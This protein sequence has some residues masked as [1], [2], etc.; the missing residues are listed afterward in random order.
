MIS[1]AAKLPVR[2]GWNATTRHIIHADDDIHNHGLIPRTASEKRRLEMWGKARCALIVFAVFFVMVSR[3][4]HSEGAVK[5]DQ[6]NPR[7][8]KKDGSE[9]VTVT[10]EHGVLKIHGG[11]FG[12]DT[13]EMAFENSGLFLPYQA[14]PVGSWPEA[15]AIGDV[16]N[17]GRNDVV[18]TTSRYFDPDN[19]YHIFVFLQNQ[20]GELE[21][22]V[23]YPAGNGESID[24]GDVNNDGKADVLVTAQD[25]IGVFLQND[26]GGLDPMVTYPSNHSSHSNTYKVGIGD[27]NDD[28][29]LDVVSID[30]GTQSHDV[31]VFLQNT[32]GTLNPPV[33]YVVEHG[34]W[35]DLEVGDVNTDGLQDIIVMSGQGAY[36]DI[37]I[38]LQREDGIFEQPVYY[39]LGSG[40]L[41]RGVGVGDI[42]GDTLE[43]IVVSYG[44][45]RPNSFIATFLQNSTGALDP[46]ISYSSYDIPEPVEVADVDLD[47]RNDV[48]VAH[49]GWNAMGVYLQGANGTL[50][51]Y[52]LYSLPY[53]SHYN[54]HGLVV[55]D[56]SGDGANDVAIADYN[57]GLVVLYNS[58]QTPG[59]PVVIIKANGQGGPFPVTVGPLDPVTV[60]ISLDPHSRVGWVADWWIGALTT[61]GTY[62]V[63]PSLT[64]KKSNKP[65]SVGQYPLFDLPETLLLNTPLP[66]GIYTFFFALDKT[67]DRIFDLTWYDY[68]NLICRGEGPPAAAVPDF[69]AFSQEK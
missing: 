41:T 55:G 42:N 29:L 8:L 30:W 23:K 68:V 33:S 66:E 52:E 56:F 51:P 49:G 18:M 14:Y 67:P 39:D 53:A 59:P 62:W 13:G 15:V 22:P 36:D 21:A 1:N 40:E 38:L 45:N 35:D 27:F 19:D 7:Y 25:A 37:G 2:M 48:I 60:T 64:W 50:L 31:D 58:N 24:I 61:F 47:G 16:N 9:W 32:G 12:P 5:D 57:H 4:A 11:A 46:P 34:G 54:P 65:I 6:K 28:G 26:S 10:K 17:D 63:D 3:A 20:Y 69:E 44:G 43:D